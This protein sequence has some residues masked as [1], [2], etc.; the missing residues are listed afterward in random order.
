M[1]WRCAGPAELL[2]L[3][4]R[5]GPFL[6]RHAAALATMLAAAAAAYGVAFGSYAAAGSDAAGYVSQA[7]LFASGQV[8]IDEPLIR[9][10]DWPGAAN[11][12]SPL[13]YRP[14]LTPGELVPT[15][16]PGLPLVM[17][18]ALLVAGPQRVFRPPCWRPGRLLHLCAGPP[19]QSALWSLC[20]GAARH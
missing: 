13:G 17:A 15:Y 2:I 1:L 8:A 12:F 11:W 7:H 20:R 10:V 18:L 19:V 5:L 16:P 14:G 9:Q 6:D 4:Q 3:A